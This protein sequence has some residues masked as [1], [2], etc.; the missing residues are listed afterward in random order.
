MQPMTAA[1]L[2]EALADLPDD[3]VVIDAATGRALVDVDPNPNGAVELAFADPRP[4]R[5]AVVNNTFVGEFHGGSLMQTGG[6]DHYGD[7]RT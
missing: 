3:Q 7:L 1:A 5:R 2:R 4:R 6:S